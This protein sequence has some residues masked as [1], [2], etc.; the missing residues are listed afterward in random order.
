[1][2]NGEDNLTAFDLAQNRSEFMSE[3]TRQGNNPDRTL[4]SPEG[5]DD[6]GDRI[7]LRD[8]AH[9]T[10]RIQLP[11]FD[12][13]PEFRNEKKASSNILGELSSPSF[14]SRRVII[15]RDVKYLDPLNRYAAAG[16][17]NPVHG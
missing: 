1:M 5:I 9:Y 11:G 17:Y 13:V 7:L 8:D 6:E 12:G 14:A 10:G 16:F 4:Q 15:Q 3:A 2:S